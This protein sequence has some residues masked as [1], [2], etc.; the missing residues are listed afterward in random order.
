M[1]KR[2]LLAIG[3]SLFALAASAQTDT[4]M[5]HFLGGV[6]MMGTDTGSV[7]PL[8]AR[9]NIRRREIFASELPAHPVTLASFFMDRT[10]V[11]NA[12]FKAFLDTNPSWTRE[13]VPADSHNGDYLKPWD[14]TGYPRGEGEL[15]VTFVTWR[16]AVAYCES[17]GKR[18][19]TEAEWEFAAD[20]GKAV[21]FPWGDEMPDGT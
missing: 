13:R 9:F 5:V 12:A 16:A 7:E 20:G 21:Q 3:A 14:E 19:P 8:M 18:L 6:F 15:P 10:E 4:E 2:V 17:R 1:L 11:T